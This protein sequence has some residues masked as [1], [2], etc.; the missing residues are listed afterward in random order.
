M[1]ER[2]LQALAKHNQ[3]GS[4]L[5]ADGGDSEEVLGQFAKAGVDIDELAVQLQQEGARSFVNSWNELMSV[6]ASKSAVL[7]KAS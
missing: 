2:T 7:E 5:P 4:I 3:L 1:P 6:I